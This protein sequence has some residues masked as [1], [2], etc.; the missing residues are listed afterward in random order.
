VIEIR[1]ILCPIDFSD[2]SRRA[3]DH[4]VA[5]ARWY[6]STITALHVFSVT[7]VAA[8]A[9]G[10]AGFDAIVLTQADRDQLLAELT[11]FIETESTPEVR[12]EAM[13]REGPTASEILSQAAD[14]K[15]D[16]LVM[17]THG[18]SGF[19]RLLLGSITEKVLR[20]A[21]CPVLTVPRRHPDAVPAAPVLFKHILCPVDFSDSS[22][23]ALNYALSLAQEA[24]AHLTAVH[25]MTYGLEETP[26]LYDTIITD[27]RLSL[28]DYRQRHEE[29]AR[30]RLKQAIPD[31]V[32]SYCSV[33]TMMVRGKPGP[34]ILRLAGERHSDVIVMGIQGRGAADLMFLGSTTNHVV[35]AATCPVLTLRGQ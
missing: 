29:S 10:A 27:S 16:L 24:D 17:G 8:Y 12:V 7:P 15:A 25:V 9:P 11:R 6:G 14:L 30:E 28:A 21:R 13:I 5:I 4:A 22:M 33:E 31:T 1:R 32:A 35:R 26:D 19:E 23:R 3:L 20:M 34:E 2:Y 18:R